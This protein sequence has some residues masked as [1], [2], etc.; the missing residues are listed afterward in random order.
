MGRLVIY[1]RLKKMLKCDSIKSRA[2][3][4]NV[5]K[6]IALLLRLLP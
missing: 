2:K 4:S 3:H 1:S 5:Y 6:I